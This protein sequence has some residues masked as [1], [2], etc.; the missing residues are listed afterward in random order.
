MKLDDTQRTLARVCLAPA[1]DDRDVAALGDRPARWHLYR[2]LV[3]NRLLEVL[4]DAL[5]GTRRALGDAGL[6]SCAA[7]FLDRAPPTTR[8][9]RELSIAFAR[10][11]EAHPAAV[12]TGAAPWAVDMARYE[13][14]VM[15]GHV[16]LDPPDDP[17]V[18]EFDMALAPALCPAQRFLRVSWSVHRAEPAT[19]E[20]A[21]LVHR[22]PV[23]D[24]VET[25]ELT[26]IAADIY[27]R[28]TRGDRSVTA[29]AEGALAAR[30]A[31]AD[32]VFV[33]SFAGLLGDLIERGVILGGRAPAG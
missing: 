7:A 11:L 10:F 25:L 17:S 31:G 14:A 21:L 6:A 26:P 13:A 4:G 29:C 27:E 23:T 22:A 24:A 32:P 16:A 20:W 1:P 33:E 9:V 15:H 8:Y 2:A 18:T 5:P 3:R 19:G 28:F 12:P 30:G